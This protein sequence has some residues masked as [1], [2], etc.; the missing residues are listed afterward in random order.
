MPDRQ[1]DGRPRPLSRKVV[2]ESGGKVP[3]IF[4]DPAVLLPEL[5]APPVAKKY[6][7]GIIPH[8]LQE[9]T[10][11]QQLAKTGRDDVKLI[12][13]LSVSFADIER[14]IDDIRSCEELVSTSLHGVIV[15]HAYGIP[16][17]SL[18]MVKSGTAGDSY[19]MT[20]YKMSVGLDDS[21]LVVRED[22]TDLDWLESRRCVVPPRL[23]DTTP[24]KGA[25]PF[26]R[27]K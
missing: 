11:R 2:T 10:F 16:C 25:F 20:D 14:V 24:L 7:L 6:K 27:R 8:V 13:L 1:L 26:P 17:Q 15:A 9:D 21:P 12:S 18:K 22:F 3:E 23:I 4:G 19:K 5:Y